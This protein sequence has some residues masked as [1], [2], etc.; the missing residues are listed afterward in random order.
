MNSCIGTLLGH[1]DE[2]LDI[3]LNYQ[4]L[5]LASASSD[6]TARMW[7]ISGDFKELF[8]LDDHREEVSTSKFKKQW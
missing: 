7:D 6:S 2:V 1:Y 8:V 5:K 4:G 3:A